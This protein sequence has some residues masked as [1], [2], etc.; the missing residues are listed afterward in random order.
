[1]PEPDSSKTRNLYHILAPCAPPPL[2]PSQSRNSF[3]TPCKPRNLANRNLFASHPGSPHTVS[4]QADVAAAGRFDSGRDAFTPASRISGFLRGGGILLRR[5][6]AH[7]TMIS[8][9]SR[10][11]GRQQLSQVPHNPLVPR[12]LSKNPHLHKIDNG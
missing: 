12:A 1:V 8:D 4:P 2:P 7:E 11:L 9:R 6:K 3:H 10:Y 5:I